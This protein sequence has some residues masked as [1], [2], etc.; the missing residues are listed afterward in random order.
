MI[1]RETAQE[2]ERAAA[3]W[4]TRADGDLSA[5]ESAE[6]QRWVEGD[7]RRLGAFARAQSIIAQ[8]RQ[9]TDDWSDASQTTDGPLARPTRRSLIGWG[10]A[11][12]AAAMAGA[13]FVAFPA[14]ATTYRTR[15]G[16]VLRIALPDG[17]A[18]TLNTDTLLRHVEAERQHRFRLERGEALFDTSASVA[19]Q[20]V[21][22]ADPLSAAAKQAS[23]SLSLYT[24]APEITVFSG[25]VLVTQ[26]R[27]GTSQTI[28]EGNRATCVRQR[29]LKV[30]RVSP[31]E[32]QRATLW[33]EGRIA[34]QDTSLRD[35]AAI[36][37]RYSDYPILVSDQA[38]H[39]TI[40]GVFAT[41]DPKRFAAAA[42]DVLGLRAEIREDGARIF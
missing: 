4:A 17:V 34:F 40:T 9:A 25:S 8:A 15:K 20:L 35:A 22:E 2:R 21:C 10:A 31:Q 12:G 26:D 32:A 16:E 33:Q 39:E 28:G 14:A 19:K 7:V 38:K 11:V 42:A 3:D 36:F 6:L 29:D 23:L 37:A 18:V 27:G 30:E 24:G 41:A 5:S 13:A 1:E